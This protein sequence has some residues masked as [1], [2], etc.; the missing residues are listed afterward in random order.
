MKD[1]YIMLPAFILDMGQNI[2]KLLDPPV[3]LKYNTGRDVTIIEKFKTLIW[4]KG[5]LF[6][7]YLTPFLLYF[8][9]KS[10]SNNFE[11]FGPIS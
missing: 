11:I 5:S 7:N 10:G 4:N 8:N 3:P 9:E 1:N 2:L 6:K